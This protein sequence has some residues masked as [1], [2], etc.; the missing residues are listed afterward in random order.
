MPAS[1]A[2]SS[3]NIIE[4]SRIPPS[5]VV[6]ERHYSV[7]EL[8]STWGLSERTIRRMF[9]SEPGIIEWGHKETRS[10]RAYRTWRIPESVAQ[11]VYRSMRRAG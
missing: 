8:A 10:R 7:K 9:A 4:S 5:G 2:S 3:Q 11:R 1:E 6:F